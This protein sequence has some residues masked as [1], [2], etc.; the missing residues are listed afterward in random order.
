MLENY[1]TAEDGVKGTTALG[2]APLSLLVRC[3]LSLLSFGQHNLSLLLCYYYVPFHLPR[4]TQ[5]GKY[6]HHGNGKNKTKI[7]QKHTGG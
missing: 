5:P 1:R 4:T 7:N 2:N 6:S 3:T